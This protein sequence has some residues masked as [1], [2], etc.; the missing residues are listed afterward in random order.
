VLGDGLK[1]EPM[2]PAAGQAQVAQLIEQ[3]RFVPMQGFTWQNVEQLNVV[4]Y[5][6]CLQSYIEAMEACLDEGLELESEFQT[7]FDLDGLLRM[8]TKTMMESIEKGVG[9]GVMAPNEGRFKLNLD[10]VTGGNSP[11]LQQQ[12]YSLEALAK[13]DA[14]QNPFATT[15]ATTPTPT[16][17]DANAPSSTSADSADMQ[18]AELD[19]LFKRHLAADLI[20]V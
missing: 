7:E 9:A 10:P 11:Y 15:P 13:R 17:S 1:F 12:N 4:Y 19:E 16:P 8:D 5:S 14:Q 2:M 3:L 20:G 6:D 18:A